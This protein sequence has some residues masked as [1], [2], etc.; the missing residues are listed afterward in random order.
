MADLAK[1]IYK[2]CPSREC[3]YRYMAI[4]SRQNQEFGYF[5]EYRKGRDKCEW[6]WD[7]NM[8]VIVE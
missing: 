7:M 6:F 2:Q 3:C 1:C 8:V 4:T 5:E